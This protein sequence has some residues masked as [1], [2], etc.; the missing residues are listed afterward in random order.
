MRVWNDEILSVSNCL[1]MNDMNPPIAKEFP[2]KT[3]ENTYY[4][5]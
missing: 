5:S 1:G 2:F 4:F 3:F